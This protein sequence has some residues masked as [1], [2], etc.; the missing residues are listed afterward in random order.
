MRGRGE[1]STGEIL[2]YLVRGKEYRLADITK[3]FDTIYIGIADSIEELLASG[4][5]VW[6]NEDSP[7][8]KRLVLASRGEFDI[9]DSRT[10]ATAFG[11]GDMTGY[12]AERNRARDLAMT[13]RR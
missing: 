9:A 10:F 5:I 1:I 3:F 8:G 12:D 13:V 11:R 4:T 2:E 6:K 7:K